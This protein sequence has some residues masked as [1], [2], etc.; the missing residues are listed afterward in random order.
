MGGRGEAV[1]VGGERAPVRHAVGGGMHVRVSFRPS[2]CMQ[3]DILAVHES[4]ESLE[5]TFR[6]EQRARQTSGGPPMVTYYENWKAFDARRYEAHTTVI[7]VALYTWRETHKIVRLQ[8]LDQG[9]PREQ[10]YRK[11]WVRLFLRRHAG[12]AVLS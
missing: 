9:L 7:S 1:L 3:S 12:G 2:P 11:P 4:S 5:Q 8:Q 6:M 10:Q